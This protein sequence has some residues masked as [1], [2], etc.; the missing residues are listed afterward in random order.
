MGMRLVDLAEVL[1]NFRRGII[2]R[3]CKFLRM[4]R[5]AAF[6]TLPGLVQACGER[7][8]SAP[9]AVND[10]F[11]KGLIVVAIVVI[12]FTNNV[13]EAGHRRGSQS[14]Q[15]FADRRKVTARIARFQARY[16]HQVR[17]P[18]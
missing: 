16:V 3:R 8:A 7:T 6:L 10:F 12:L 11:V 1:Q 9:G 2:Y 4:N 15:A 14:W 18:R 13:H 17:I 5:T